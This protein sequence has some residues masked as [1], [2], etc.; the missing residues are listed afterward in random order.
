M[1]PLDPRRIYLRLVDEPPI[2][3]SGE[4][5]LENV[6]RAVERLAPLR[7]EEGYPRV[8]ARGGWDAIFHVNLAPDETTFDQWIKQLRADGYSPVI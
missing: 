2:A 1:P 5:H 8:N 7:W 4:M 3:A 6:R